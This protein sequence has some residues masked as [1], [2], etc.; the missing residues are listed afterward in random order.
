MM[1]SIDILGEKNPCAFRNQT[2]SFDKIKTIIS[3][4]KW[5][6]NVIWVIMSSEHEF[7]CE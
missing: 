4:E 2:N 1:C 3:W 7:N 6:M 5:E